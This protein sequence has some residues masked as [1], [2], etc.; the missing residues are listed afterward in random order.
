MYLWIKINK[1]GTY[2]RIIK[3]TFSA[4]NPEDWEY[5]FTKEQFYNYNFIS[6]IINYTHS[7][8]STSWF[9]PLDLPTNCQ[10]PYYIHAG[11][12]GINNPLSPE[13]MYFA[14]FNRWHMEN[15]NVVPIFKMSNVKH[16]I[17]LDVTI[18]LFRI[19]A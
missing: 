11:F 17:P 5:K 3:K 14:I 1:L 10:I 12:E 4:E 13:K 15:G 6:V 18:T 19:Y 7:G 8:V 9:S 16:K 2:K